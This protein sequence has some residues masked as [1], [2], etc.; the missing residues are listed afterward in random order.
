MKI[1]KQGK[2]KKQLITS[3]YNYTNDEQL[4]MDLDAFCMHSGK[5]GVT[6]IDS[7]EG[8]VVKLTF[9][10]VVIFDN[11]IHFICEI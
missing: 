7:H 11:P 2:G 9:A 8:N 10:S 1:Y 6:T 5:F 3:T 4:R